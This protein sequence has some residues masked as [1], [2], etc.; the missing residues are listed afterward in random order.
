MTRAKGDFKK[1]IQLTLKDLLLILNRGGASLDFKTGRD[2]KKKG[3]IVS[4]KDTET[5]IKNA[6]RR[7]LKEVLNEVN[8]ALKT[9]VYNPEANKN[10]LLGF[11]IE[12]NDLFIDVSKCLK[13]D[14]KNIY[15]VKNEAFIN[16]QY[17]VYNNETGETFRLIIPIYTLY[18]TSDLL[19]RPN[20]E[21]IAN[22]S[23]GFYTVADVKKFLGIT[24]DG[25]E[26]FIFDSVDDIPDDYNLS[27]IVIRDLSNYTRDILED[28]TSLSIEDALKYSRLIKEEF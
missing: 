16:N 12:N 24:T 8:E 5:I 27:K 20:A 10:N 15:K 4:I 26:R 11:W 25:G 22:Y 3:F 18:N 28:D 19:G 1:M 17:A 7:D 9:S 14:L 21:N 6:T 23:R 13:V 2:T